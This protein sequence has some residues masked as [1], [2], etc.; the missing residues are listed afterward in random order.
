MPYICSNDGHTLGLHL[1]DW[2]KAMRSTIH[3]YDGSRTCRVVIPEW[4]VQSVR[5]AARI[6]SSLGNLPRSPLPSLASMCNHRM[7]PSRSTRKW[8]TS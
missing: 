2:V 7:I 6:S 8:P 3:L 5:A 1:G 4:A